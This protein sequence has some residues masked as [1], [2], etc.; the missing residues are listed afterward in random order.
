MKS[1]KYQKKFADSN[2]NVCLFQS[3]GRGGKT[4]AGI[5]RLQKLY[6]KGIRKVVIFTRNK[7]EK[8][9]FEILCSRNL[10]KD[11]NIDIH[12]MK[13]CEII[14]VDEIP[15]KYFMATYTP[16][17]SFDII[18]NDVFDNDHLPKDYKDFIERIGAKKR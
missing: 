1:T 6:K 17:G 14:W 7:W 13:P 15:T 9:N 3:G 8:D 2:A 18:K 4:Y 12:I 5:I 11:M 16:N 10:P